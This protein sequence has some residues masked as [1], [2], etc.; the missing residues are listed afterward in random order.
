VILRDTW[1]SGSHKWIHSI[2]SCCKYPWQLQLFLHPLQVGT[3][4]VPRTKSSVVW[5]GTV[6]SPGL[7]SDPHVLL[8]DDKTRPVRFY[9][10]QRFSCCSFD[11]KVLQHSW[12]YVENHLTSECLS[13]TKALTWKHES[14]TDSISVNQNLLINRTCYYKILI[15]CMSEVRVLRM[16]N[17][18]NLSCGVHICSL[19]HSLR[20]I[21]PWLNHKRTL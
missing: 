3:L 12:H 8:G 17:M 2:H 16:Y 4:S 15:T 1:S 14:K 6:S 10:R 5:V 13:S 19:W 21:I 18:N 7:K 9:G 20:K 11:S